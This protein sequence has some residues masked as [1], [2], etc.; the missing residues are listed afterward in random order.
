[1][2]KQFERIE[3]A[4]REFIEKQRIFFNASATAEGRVNVSPRDVASLRVLDTNG[5]VYLDQTGSG[6][7]TAAHLRE[8]GQVDGRLT[9]MFCAFEGAPMVLRL[10]GRG[11][12][13]SRGSSEYAAMLTSEFGGVETPGARQMV[14]LK[15]ESVQTSCGYGVPLFEY[16]GERTTLTR[17]AESKGESG[18]EE[19]WRQKNMYSIDGLPTGLFEDVSA[20]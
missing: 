18:L 7:E 9:L 13:V 16:V 20:S 12:I 19:Y 14:L 3:P 8:N 15:V 4:H 5:V 1:M 10:Y 11:R 2:G 17:W 6:N